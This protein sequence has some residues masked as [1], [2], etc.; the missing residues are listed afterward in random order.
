MGKINFTA[1][2]M[3]KLK[4]LAIDMVFSNDTVTTKLGQSLG[5]TE[6]IHTTTIGTL[7][8]IRLSL[9]KKIENYENQD[10]WVSDDTNKEGLARA[11]KQKELVNLIIGYKRY[12]DELAETKALKT[13]LTEQL[14]QLKESQKS[15]ADKIKE[16][17]EQLASL[18][19]TENF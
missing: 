10:E 19:T 5:I 1:E 3:S 13:K 8:A 17:E 16:I 2:N 18:N 11:K 12:N 4:E 14:N 15:P 9:A 6:L 7:N